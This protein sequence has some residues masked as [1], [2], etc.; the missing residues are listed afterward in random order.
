MQIYLIYITTRDRAQARQIGRYLVESRL[1]ACANIMD[2]M[3]SIY[4]WQGQLQDDHE[5]VLIAKTTQTR[6]KD[7]TDAVKERHDYECPCIV[8]VPIAEGNPDF[9]D[10]IVGQVDD[11]K[12]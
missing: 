10:W 8:A 4:I 3:N 7:L 9:L 2:N 1:A 5:A 12:E 11:C 6:L